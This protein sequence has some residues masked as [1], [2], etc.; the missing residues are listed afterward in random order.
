[1]IRPDDPTVG[2]FASKV[3]CA[4]AFKQNKF[5][6]LAV[7]GKKQHSSVSMDFAQQR[8]DVADGAA[9]LQRLG[10]ECIDRQVWFSWRRLVPDR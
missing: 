8:F 10:Q 3:I 9:K 2:R 7:N 1:M 6:G 4:G 5:F